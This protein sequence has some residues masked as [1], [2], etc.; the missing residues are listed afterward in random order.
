MIRLCEEPKKVLRKWVVSLVPLTKII[1][2][3]NIISFVK[4]SEEKICIADD[5]LTLSCMEEWQRV[6][7]LYLRV[8]VEG[9][10]LCQLNIINV[11]LNNNS[12]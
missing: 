5:H 1:L 9:D 3:I 12:K 7:K 6:K 10:S 2:N 11:N 8:M 4:K